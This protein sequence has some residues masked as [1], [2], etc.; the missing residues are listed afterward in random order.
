MNKLQAGPL[1]VR[2]DYGFLRRI[3]YGETEV[4]RMIYFALRDHNWNTIDLH[5]ENENITINENNFQITYDCFHS[6]AKMR[7]FVRVVP[8]KSDSLTSAFRF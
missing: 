3:T 4:L 5:I 8:I 2:Y 1:S 7:K 6:T